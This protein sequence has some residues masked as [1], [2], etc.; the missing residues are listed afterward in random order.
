MRVLGVTTGQEV[1]VGSREKN[2]RINEL[3]IIEDKNQQNLIGEVVDAQTYNRYIPLN[4]EG[5][6]IDDGVLKSLASMGYDVDSEIVYVGKLRLHTEAKYPVL[7]GSRVREPEF[8]EIKKLLL[9]VQ[10][11]DGLIL[12]VTKNTDNLYSHAPSEYRD[13]LSLYLNDEV[14]KQED[15]PYV[16][17]YRGMNEYPHIGVFGGSGSGKSFGLRVLLEEIMKKSIPSIVLDPHYE[18]DFS[19]SLDGEDF[20]DSFKILEIG[21]DIGVKFESLNSYEL[22]NLLDAV[23]TLTDSMRNVV[24]TIFSYGQGFELFRSRLDYLIQAQEYGSS[25]SIRNAMNYQDPGDRN[26]LSEILEVYEKYG[27]NCAPQSVRG[28]FWRLNR[29]EK[30]G[31]FGRDINSIVDNLENGKLTVLRGSTRMIQVFS[32]YILNKLY[33]RRRDYRDAVYRGEVGDYFPPFII[34]TDE[35]HNFAPKGYDTPSKSILKEISP[36]GRKYGVFLVLATQRPTLL[37]ETITA[38]LNTKLIFRTVRAS[39]IDTIKEETDITSEEAKRLPYL[40]TGDVFI[41]SA[42]MGKTSYVRIRAAHTTSPHKLNP[43]DE[44]VNKST[45]DANSL[46]EKL[47]DSFPIKPEIDGMHIAKYLESEHGI[48]LSVEQLKMRLEKLYQEGYI[49]RKENLFGVVYGEK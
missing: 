47:K 18:M 16:F 20:T 38:Q 2:F 11:K 23:S 5:D 8:E 39:D 3:L 21:K 35:S 31:V 22:T 13:I 12:G 43:F 27:K 42:Q 32:A 15:L 45:E 40:V 26:D 29:L 49:D 14:V 33:Y 6:F 44:L 36:E 30:E 25:E 34:I 19:N 10:P 41:S 7:A 9:P 1:F 17:N 46:L 37:D 4:M 24:D 48:K 28:V